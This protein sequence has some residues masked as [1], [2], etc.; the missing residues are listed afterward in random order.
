MLISVQ[1]VDTNLEEDPDAIKDLF[2]K[3]LTDICCSFKATQDQEEE[4]VIINYHKL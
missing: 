3:F 1:C 4:E 2:L